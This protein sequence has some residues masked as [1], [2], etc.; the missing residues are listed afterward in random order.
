MTPNLSPAVY[1]LEREIA[2]L[3]VED[4]LWLKAQIDRQIKSAALA[5]VLTL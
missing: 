2:S 1:Q 4:K 5:Q 3:P